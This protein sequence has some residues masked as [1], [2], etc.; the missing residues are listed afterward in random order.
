MDD[1]SEIIRCEIPDVLQI[2]EDECWFEG[3][4]CGHAVSRTDPVVQKR[5]A[6]VILKG[7]GAY[8]RRKHAKAVQRARGSVATDR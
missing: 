6:D 5:V 1:A 7:A 2:V 4:R 3:E 8:L